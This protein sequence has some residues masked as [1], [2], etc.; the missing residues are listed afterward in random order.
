VEMG[1]TR[2]VFENPLHPYT[3]MLIASVP[4]LHGKWKQVDGAPMAYEAGGELVEV[5][6][7]HHVALPETQ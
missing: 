5:E 1:A 7:D 6:D 2:R 4:Q 3:R